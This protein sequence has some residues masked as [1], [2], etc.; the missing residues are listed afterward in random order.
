M[1]FAVGPTDPVPDATVKVVGAWPMRA[2]RG[3]TVRQRL[4]AFVVVG[5]VLVVAVAATGLISV[6][7]VR[8]RGDEITE[9]TTVRNDLNQ[10][11]EA[12]RGTRSDVDQSIFAGQGVVQ[13][14]Q[15]EA[16]QASQA[17]ITVISSTLGDAQAQRVP[18]SVHSQINGLT[19]E[20][21]T[22]LTEAGRLLNLAYTNLSAATAA[23]PAFHKM[24]DEVITGL[25]ATLASVELLVVE[26]RDRSSHTLRTTATVLVGMLVLTIFLLGLCASVI[27]R[28]LRRTLRTLSDVA[29]S[30]ARGDL[31][32]RAVVT[33]SDELGT[34]G[35]AINDMAGD[36]QVLVEQMETTAQRDGFG[37]QLSEALEMAD[38]EAE[39]L[40]V[41][42]RA[43]AS[44]STTIP[45]EILLADSSK[46][47]LACAASNP[48]SGAP[49]CPVESPFS[50]V[51]VRR[52]NPVVF[53]DSEALN[54]C[55]KLRGRPAGPISAVC[56]P[57][58]FMGR[59]LGVL[60]STGPIGATP[61]AESASRLTSLATQAGARI[62]TV[63][64]FE[65][66][67][68]QAT[69]DGLTGLRNRRTVEIEV[70]ALLN[71]GAQLM[72]VMADLDH[73]KLLND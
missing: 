66:S 11:G 9:L 67:Q 70:R 24:G 48:I 73:F 5:V 56:V 14:T 28:S 32:A 16:L 22:F 38:T 1:T 37:S 18:V 33:S 29:R 8:D 17:L 19:P 60:H 39:A 25:H 46:A 26:A 20:L 42:E 44:I 68:L 2:T 4:R 71:E 64:S 47:H 61:A 15:V 21:S 30:I 51:A 62:G 36:L 53:D 43:M 40:S 72:L 63:R 23:L 31:G 12:I 54:A 41:I 6:S 50:C 65:R 34:L 7:Y 10:F 52:G 69:T 58:T 59:A 45:M 3:G 57:V 35:H 55:P 49:G 13:L 27:G